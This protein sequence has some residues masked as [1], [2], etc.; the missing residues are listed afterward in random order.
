M[1]FLHFHQNGNHSSSAQAKG[2]MVDGSQQSSDGAG[3][4]GEGNKCTFV[5][6][7]NVV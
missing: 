5:M 1:G 4:A 3:V 7:E 2:S 6:G